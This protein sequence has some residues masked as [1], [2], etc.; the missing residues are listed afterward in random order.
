[1]REAAHPLILVPGSIGV[2]KTTLASV[3]HERFGIPA[4]IEHADRNP[5]LAGLYEDPARWAYPAHE[6]FLEHALGRMREAGRAG[7]AAVVDRSPPESV[8]VFARML[9]EMG[10][11]SE[12][13]LASL[14]ARL[15]A[16]MQ[17]LVAPSLMLYLH[18]PVDEL[19]ERIRSR[20]VSE[21]RSIA[22]DY[23][24]ALG[25]HYTRF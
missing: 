14:D 19:I 2:G 22:A 12:P 9:S 8:H 17:D 20:D 25:A 10:H 3:V 16:A 6:V 24:T 21:E 1:M 11:I 4:W 18:A 15:A 23:L 13:Q 5:H 7:S